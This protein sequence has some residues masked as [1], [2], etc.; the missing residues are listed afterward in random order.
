MARL[1]VRP[2]LDPDEPDAPVAVLLVDPDGSPGERAM[3]RLGAYCYEGDGVFYLVQT[4]GW[5]EHAREGGRLAVDIAVYPAAL[6][7]VD[8]DPADF[9]LRSTVDSR[10]VLVLH[11]ET[12][13]DPE[14]DV[15]LSEGTAVFT[16][17]RPGTTLD[18]VLA[19]AE[20]WPIVLAPPPEELQ[21][22][23]PPDE[24]A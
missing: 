13:V 3:E 6:K 14:P 11:A 7:A 5:A 15:Q 23:D 18:D 2:G 4:D 10:A 12:T 1:Y 17:A 20:D 16:C 8:V 9:P 22:D 19:S 21:E 24:D